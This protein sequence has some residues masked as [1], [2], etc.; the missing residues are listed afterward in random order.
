[1][2]ALAVAVAC[3]RAAAWASGIWKRG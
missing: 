2:I 1:M 3:A